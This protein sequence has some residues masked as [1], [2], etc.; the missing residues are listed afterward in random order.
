MARR[1]GPQ[2]SETSHTILDGAERVLQNS[3]YGAITSRSIAEAAGV[4]QQLVYYYFKDIDELLLA[5][6]KRRIARGLVRLREDIA[7]SRPLRAIWN[8]LS[9]AVDARLTFEYMALANHHAGIREEVANF[10][11]EMRQLQI[12][13]VRDAYAK[14]GIASGMVS[15]EAIVFL[16]GAV[17]IFMARETQT[18]VSI[19]HPEMNALI[20]NFLQQF[21]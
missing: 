8:D 19:T 4:K 14:K 13:C 17:S 21:D 6:F 15:P 2:D 18:G 11:V 5:A 10:M 12:D 9:N 7:S 20:E 1:M 16:V 3:G